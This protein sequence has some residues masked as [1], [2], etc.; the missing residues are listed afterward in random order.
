VSEV[1][2]TAAHPS[3]RSNVIINRKNIAEENTAALPVGH[4]RL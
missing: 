4:Q 3:R 2:F 1:T